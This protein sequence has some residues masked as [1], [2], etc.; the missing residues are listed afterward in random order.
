[1]VGEFVEPW[2]VLVLL[3]LRLSKE[4]GEIGGRAEPQVF[5]EAP[6]IRFLVIGFTGWKCAGMVVGFGWKLLRRNRMS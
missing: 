5:R 2:L 3:V 4:G 6:D 1:M